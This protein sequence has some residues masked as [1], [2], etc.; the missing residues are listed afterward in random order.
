MSNQH[1]SI[2][3]ENSEGSDLLAELAGEATQRNKAL[4]SEEQNLQERSQNLHAAL[5]KI[6]QYFN[7]FS[8]HLNKIKPTTPRVYS[9]DPLTAYSNI[10]WGEARVDSRKQSLSDKALVDHVSM[11]VKLTATNPVLTKRRWNELDN[12]KKELDNLG[13]RPLEDLNVQARKQ[14]Q[15]EFF[16]LELAPDF[17][18]RIQFQGNYDTG[19]IDLLSNNFDGFGLAAHVL[20]PADVDQRL[21]D[22]IGR[23]LIGRNDSLPEIMS[24]TRFKPQ[25]ANYR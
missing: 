25:H 2:G 18:M 7:Q 20:D 23:F 1:S 24:K 5:S 9:V 10:Q 11:I 12:L 22:D 4:Q 8:S 19:K 21:L 6:F 17:Q 15:Q 16:Q 14:P 13:L 3:N